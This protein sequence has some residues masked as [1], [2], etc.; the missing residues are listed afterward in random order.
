MAGPPTYEDAAEL[1]LRLAGEELHVEHLREAVLVAPYG[2]HLRKRISRDHVPPEPFNN[3][4]LYYT[5]TGVN[6]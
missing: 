5:S 3:L 4:I 6:P 1:R 2:G